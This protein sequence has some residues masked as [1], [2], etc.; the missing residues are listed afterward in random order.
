MADTDSD[1]DTYSGIDSSLDGS[2][3]G[4]IVHEHGGDSGVGVIEFGSLDDQPIS[5]GGDVPMRPLAT[6]REI[7]GMDDHE[8]TSAVGPDPWHGPDVEF[9]F[10]A[11]TDPFQEFFEQEERIVERYLMRSPDDFSRHQ[12]V[13]SCEGA[14]LVRQLA[15]LADGQPVGDA[16]P[17]DGRSRG[18]IAGPS[19]GESL[20]V[21][22]PGPRATP[23]AADVDDS[24]MVVIEEDLLA[25]P[26]GRPAVAAVRLGDYRRLFARLRRGG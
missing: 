18:G 3:N 25:Q 22:E 17:H 15:E 5:R 14:A 12:H 9:V 23:P 20:P 21:I 6:L 1:I 13:A 26:A 10:D 19:G 2:S 4:F 24:D 11:S 7:I 8:P 16:R